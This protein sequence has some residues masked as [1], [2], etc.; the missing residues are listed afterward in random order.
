MSEHDNL[1]T[2]AQVFLIQAETLPKELSRYA[3]DDARVLLRDL[4]TALDRAQAYGVSEHNIVADIWGLLGVQTSE[5]TKGK[6]LQE[7]VRESLNRAETA[8]SALADEMQEGSFISQDW[9][10]K[11]DAAEAALCE[12]RNDL[13]KAMLREHRLRDALESI[14]DIIFWMSGS[15]D[16]GPE[17]QAHKGWVASQ[18][19][20][21]KARAA[22]AHDAEPVVNQGQD[23]STP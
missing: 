10:Q 20:L 7:W 16:F 23:V 9:A 1:R 3:L 5:Q 22:L 19:A 21:A 13:Q 8:E 18:P 14:V 2:R 11:L 6:S 12:T 4:L 15:N 17:G